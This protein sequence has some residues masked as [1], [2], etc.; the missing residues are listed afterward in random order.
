MRQPQVTFHRKSQIAVSMALTLAAC[1]GTRGGPIPYNVSN[2]GRPDAP[3]TD[4][5]PANYQ[6]APMDTLTIKVY[7]VDA[8]TSDYTV[9][10]M[11]NIAIP[12]IG[13]VPAA[14]RSPDQFDKIL[15]AK[16]GEKYFE[17]P[18]VTVSIKASAGRSVTVDGAVARA[19][20]YPVP[21]TMTLMQAVALAGGITD[22]ANA[23]RIAIFR[24]IDGRR[25]AAAFDLVSIRRGELRD[26][27]VYAGD[28]IVVDGSTIN[29]TLKRVFMTTPLLRIFSPVVF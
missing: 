7:G 4:V 9:D 24:T 5:L 18:D 15:T 16:L 29:A 14:G 12:L 21:T 26:P 10:L 17:H 20:A 11:G 6:I 8:L 28:I 25:E 13:D 22:D 19:G 2:F 3:T 23:H 1:A 27:P